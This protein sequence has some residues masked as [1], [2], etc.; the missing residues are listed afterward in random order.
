MKTISDSLS[1]EIRRLNYWYEIFA[2]KGSTQKSI[3]S[4]NFSKSLIKQIASGRKP[5][6][7][8]YDSQIKASLE[9]SALE[10][11]DKATLRSISRKIICKDYPNFKCSD[12]YI[13]RLVKRLHLRKEQV[14]FP[15]SCQKFI[16]F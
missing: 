15:D 16:K 11:V 9:E 8:S 5:F 3:F 4:Q 6:Y 10:C 13:M 1:V 12:T 7:K 2:L 14:I